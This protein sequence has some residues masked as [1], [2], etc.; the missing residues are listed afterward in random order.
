MRYNDV[1]IDKASNSLT[2][3]IASSHGRI[4]TFEELRATLPDILPEPE[5]VIPPEK[6][7]YEPVMSIGVHLPLNRDKRSRIGHLTQMRV[8]R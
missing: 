2:F 5:E 4:A 1:I 8:R 6:P 7:V 3:E